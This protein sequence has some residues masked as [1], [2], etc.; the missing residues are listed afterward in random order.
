MWSAKC[1]FYFYIEDNIYY[2]YIRI[3]VRV[4]RNDWNLL[5]EVKENAQLTWANAYDEGDYIPTAFSLQK[6]TL[7]MAITGYIVLQFVAPRKKTDPYKAPSI[8][9]TSCSVFLIK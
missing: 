3:G 6:A 5:G 7:S 4:S 9:N 8:L 1:H 2:Q